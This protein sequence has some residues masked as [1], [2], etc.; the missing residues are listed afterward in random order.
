[1]IICRDK[2]TAA[3]FDQGIDKKDLDVIEVEEEVFSFTVVAL[4]VCSDL[5]PP[6]STAHVSPR[7]MPT[8]VFPKIKMNPIPLFDGPTQTI[9]G[10]DTAIPVC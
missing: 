9:S 1:M 6:I 3:D 8:K 7:I 2:N 4:G 5:Q 10:K